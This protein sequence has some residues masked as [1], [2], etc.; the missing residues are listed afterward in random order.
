MAKEV[1]EMFCRITQC[2]SYDDTLNIM[3][4]C[5]EPTAIDEQYSVLISQ[6]NEGKRKGQNILLQ[7][8][9]QHRSI[10]LGFITKD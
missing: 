2:D 3:M 10:L 9:F 5:I 7:Y 8:R 4:E 1:D 6:R